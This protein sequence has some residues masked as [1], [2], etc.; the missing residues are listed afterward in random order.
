MATLVK[1]CKTF[2]LS[3]KLSWKDIRTKVEGVKFID[4]RRAVMVFNKSAVKMTLLGCNNFDVIKTCSVY[5]GEGDNGNGEDEVATLRSVVK[6]SGMKATYVNSTT[7][8]FSVFRVRTDVSIDTFRCYQLLYRLG[9][10]VAMDRELHDALLITD[11][12]VVWSISDTVPQKILASVSGCGPSEA[13]R[14]V[15]KS[16]RQIGLF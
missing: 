2:H 7:Y 15:N 5:G 12:R 10:I 11:D 14:L 6:A 1:T 4:E 8:D 16:R 9:A 13:R 3:N